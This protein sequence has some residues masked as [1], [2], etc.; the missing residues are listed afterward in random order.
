MPSWAPFLFFDLVS[1]THKILAPRLMLL[2][3]LGHFLTIRLLPFFAACCCPNVVR[4]GC[5]DGMLATKLF[6]HLIG[7]FTFLLAR[8]VNLAVAA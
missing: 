7:S 4:V 2:Y 1:S 8:L 5:Y 6:G 3:F